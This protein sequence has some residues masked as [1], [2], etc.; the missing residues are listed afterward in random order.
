[1]MDEYRSHSAAQ[2]RHAYAARDLAEH[3]ARM[4][5]A[6]RRKAISDTAW[7]VVVAGLAIA[8]ILLAGGVL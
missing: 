7:I 6:D 1:M 3:H 2:D 5:R 4:K 8:L